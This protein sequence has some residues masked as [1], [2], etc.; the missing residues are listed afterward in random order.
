MK[1][2]LINYLSALLLLAIPISCN[3]TKSKRIRIWCFCK[4]QFFLRGNLGLQQ[5]SQATP[6]ILAWSQMIL[7]IIHWL[8]M[9]TLKK[10]HDPT[11]TYIQV[12]RFLLSL[13]VRDIINW[14]DSQGKP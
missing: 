8:A 3:S 14:K 10:A 7:P 2:K 6:T 12:G 1:N 11:G 9:C 5:T 4:K 13:M